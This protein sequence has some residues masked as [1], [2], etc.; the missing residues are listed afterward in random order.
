M[1][2]NK[3]LNTFFLA[4]A[5]FL[6]SISSAFAGSQ[7]FLLM[8][9]T[10]YDIY[11]INISPSE[12]KEWEEDVL[13]SQILANGETLEV[14]FSKR[15]ERYWD[16]QVKF[17]DGSGLYWMHLDLMNTKFIALNGDGTATMK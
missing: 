17:K 1:N 13:G 14:K 7:D 5:F 9:R 8:N 12:T 6:L 3:F 11:A 15:K 16:I 2:H 10:G 4:V